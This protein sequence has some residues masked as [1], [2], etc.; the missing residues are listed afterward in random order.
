M[1]LEHI[2]SLIGGGA[3]GGA[4]AWF[5]WI[6]KQ[7]NSIQVQQEKDNYVAKQIREGDAYKTLLVVVEDMKGTVAYQGTQIAGLRKELQAERDVCDS[8]QRA[9]NLKIADLEF[10]NYQQAAKIKW[11]EDRVDEMQH[12]VLPAT[13]AAVASVLV[14][15]AAA[16]ERKVVANAV[17]VAGRVE[18]KAAVVATSLTDTAD[19]AAA[20]LAKALP[21]STAAET[22]ARHNE[23]NLKQ[24]AQFKAELADLKSKVQ[25]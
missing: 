4:S 23:A 18:D 17:D 8:I 12:S 3:I 20:E 9:Q 15:T 6:W 1:D 7:K 2:S 5:F 14:S 22:E 25:P 24:V 10:T 19:M 21:A 11:L 13:A 16:A